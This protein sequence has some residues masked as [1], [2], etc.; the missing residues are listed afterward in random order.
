MEYVNTT[1]VPLSVAAWLA[2]DSYDHNPDPYAISATELLKPVKQIVLG[3]RAAVQ[4]PTAVDISTLVP[5]RMGT[6]YHDGIERAWLDNYEESLKALG[7]PPGVV[8]RI[9]VN[10]ED[11][12]DLSECI[13]V[14]LEQRA[15]KKVGRWTVS[16]KF[17][18]IGDGRLE[19]F[20]STSTFT[21]TN[22][23]NDQK[24]I[25]QGS[26]YRWLNPTKIT[27]DQMAIQFIFTDWNANKAK[28]DKNYPKSRILE[29]PLQLIS[30]AET[31]AYIKRKLMDVDTYMDSP[32]S[33]MPP[34]TDEELWRSK[35]QWKYYSKQDS[36][37][38]YRTFDN[39]QDANTLLAQRGAG[40]VKEFKS[41]PKACRYCAA[42]SICSQAQKFVDEGSLKV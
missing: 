1:N 10:P 28:S 5:S 15:E 20:K 24:Y 41:E 2:H 34:C 27:N 21:Y 30:V 40:Y 33:A 6:A 8:K 11:H 38:A 17:D 3:R 35:P 16:G 13:P 7:Y 9:K 37:R 12:E 4:Q 32:E 31:D 42:F 23:T 25:M 36:K 19:D 26:V 18:F 29:Y 22:K 14:Y 39:P